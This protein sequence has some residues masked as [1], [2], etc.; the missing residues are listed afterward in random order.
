M[1]MNIFPVGTPVGTII[2][3]YNV[4]ILGLKENHHWKFCDGRM[5]N[6]NKWNLLF[7]VIGY[8]FSNN[9]NEARLPNIEGAMIKVK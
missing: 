7:G 9:E 4:A 3:P 6:P 1:K 2:P 8:S 5:F